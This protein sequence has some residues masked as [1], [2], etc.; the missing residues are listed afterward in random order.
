MNV[1]I[2]EQCNDLGINEDIARRLSDA[3]NAAPGTVDMEA[4]AKDIKVI[5]DRFKIPG[6]EG[7]L[8][9][10]SF[11]FSDLGKLFHD[12]FY[13]KTDKDKRYTISQAAEILGITPM[14]V[15]KKATRYDVI[16]KEPNGMIIYESDLKELWPKK[17]PDGTTPGKKALDSIENAK[18]NGRK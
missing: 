15:R 5:L 18:K 12:A 8:I 10:E 4:V 6:V 13:L 7:A 9:P 14:A 1:R 11:L 17:F 16:V 3:I 2:M